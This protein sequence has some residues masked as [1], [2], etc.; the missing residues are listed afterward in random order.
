MDS[1]EF[2]PCIVEG[3][4]CY[5]H[6]VREMRECSHTVYSSSD[7]M[8]N[9]CDYAIYSMNYLYACFTQQHIEP[10]HNTWIRMSTVRPNART[11]DYFYQSVYHHLTLDEEACKNIEIKLFSLSRLMETVCKS[12]LENLMETNFDNY[13]VGEPWF[14]M[15]CEDMEYTPMYVSRGWTHIA[16]VTSNATATSKANANATESSKKHRPIVIGAKSSIT[17]LSVEY[18]IKTDDDNKTYKIP[19]ELD[20]AWYYAGNLLFTPAHVLHLLEHQSEPFVFGMNYTIRLMDNSIHMVE[21]TVDEHIVL[22]RDSYD[23]VMV[24]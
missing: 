23:V 1:T 16:N 21:L 5:S 17:F 15:K 19:L 2:S 11:G 7:F 6:C 14:C 4:V 24:S 10:M 13:I 12:M 20:A 9:A 3:L 8:R 18:C 22:G